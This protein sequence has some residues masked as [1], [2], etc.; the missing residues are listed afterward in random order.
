M[1]SVVNSKTKALEE[2]AAKVHGV[3]Q[4]E[5]KRQ[6]L[7]IEYSDDY[8]N[9]SET[10]KDFDRA[11]AKFIIQQ[12]KE[13]RKKID[14]LAKQFEKIKEERN[15]FLKI[16]RMDNKKELRMERKSKK[17]NLIDNAIKLG[18]IRKG[19]T[20]YTEG[21]LIDRNEQDVTSEW[22]QLE[23]FVNQHRKITVKIG[24]S[25]KDIAD[26]SK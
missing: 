6:G 14:D 10:T 2:L 9:L 15:D 18:L 23:Y 5:A 7:P 11:I 12:D 21:M 1:K 22:N 13:L 4:E 19:E 26:G 3:Y 16:L 25:K 24:L 20:K 8:N 17:I